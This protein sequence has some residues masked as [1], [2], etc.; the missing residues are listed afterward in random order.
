MA[1]FQLGDLVRILGLLK[2][3]GRIV[4]LE[5]QS[6]FEDETYLVRVDQTGLLSL[7]P[8]SQLELIEKTSQ[9]RA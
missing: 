6:P 4:A 5:E 1:T 9:A 7:F 2:Y 8:E 3:T